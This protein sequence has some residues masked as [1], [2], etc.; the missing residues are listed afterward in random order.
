MWP[1]FRTANSAISLAHAMVLDILLGVSLRFRKWIGPPH[2][3]H[4]S[5]SV[6]TIFEPRLVAVVE[7]DQKLIRAGDAVA[8]LLHMDNL[9]A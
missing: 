5:T 6:M 1:R 2:H 9:P 8:L 3:L 7:I 4:S